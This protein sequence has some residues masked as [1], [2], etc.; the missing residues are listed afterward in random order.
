MASNNLRGIV[1]NRDIHVSTLLDILKE[2]ELVTE[3]SNSVLNIT[4]THITINSKDVIPG[5]FFVCKGARFKEEYLAAAVDQGAALYMADHIFPGVDIPY[6]I[7][8]DIRK[9]M[10]L[11]ARWFYDNPGDKMVKVGST[12]TK[13]KTTVT[14]VIKDILDKYTDNHCSAFSTHE[15]DIG[16]EVF[17]TTLTTP[18]PI[19]LQTYYDMAIKK[20]C[21]HCIME[22]SSQA[23]KMN[24]IYGESYK[25]GVFTNIDHDHIS[26]TEHSS[27]ED[28][29]HCKVS[30]LKQ[31][32][33][34]VLYSDTRY[35]EE[36]Y[37]EVRDK[38]V[39]V[40]GTKE[41][42]EKHMAEKDD[43]FEADT[44]FAMIHN[45]ELNSRNS[46]FELIYDGV[47]RAYDTNLLGDYN[48]ENVVAAIVSCHIMGV[49]DDI[50]KSAVKDVYVP[51]RLQVYYYKDRTFMIDYAHNY[52]SMYRLY[53]MVKKTMKPKSIT[54]VFGCGGERY[55]KR[56]EDMGRLA[57]QYA[58]KVVLTMEDPGFESCE[59][60]CKEIK[61]YITK[62][63]Y[64]IVDR[65]QALTRALDEAQPGELVITTGKG[66]ES[67][68]RIRGQFVQC[69]S[70]DQVIENWLA[71]HRE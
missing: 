25:V 10:A 49:P 61:Q 4:P 41:S 24:R 29:L 45:E 47:N 46:H 18:E 64:I 17:E 59:E 53:E 1:M 28:Y 2:K 54:V 62:P 23:M 40:Y 8:N 42:I 30:F 57:E 65:E 14:F 43:F 56:R 9:G 5:T 68:Q 19:E 16:T 20:E 13:G 26:P 52:I 7:V 38:H 69:H 63:C 37:N 22:V 50:I 55:K 44:E 15:I 27:M 11:L 21:T 66:I 51:G 33:N 6:I 32:E 31:C 71:N 34:V 70:D 35:F 12:G 60:I 39:V 67:T 36:I 48:V 58:D 3:Y